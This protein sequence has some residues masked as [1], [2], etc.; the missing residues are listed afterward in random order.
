MPWNECPR[1]RGIGA[2]LPWN[3]HPTS[4]NLQETGLSSQVRDLM[5]QSVEA[6]IHATIKARFS[7]QCR[8]AAW[9]PSC[10]NSISQ[11]TAPA[12]PCIS[13]SEQEKHFNFFGSSAQ[14]YWVMG[15]EFS[16]KLFCIHLIFT[17]RRLNKIAANQTSATDFSGGGF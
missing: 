9:S 16:N 7:L 13:E 14:L 3:A 5:V 17:L 1:S 8:K 4:K 6:D 12:H 15:L 10:P 2:Q 11:F